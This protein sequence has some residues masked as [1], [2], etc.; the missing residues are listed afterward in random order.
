MNLGFH[1][2][3]SVSA[4]GTGLSVS[5]SSPLWSQASSV[6]SPRRKASG[7][8]PSIVNTSNGQKGGCARLFRYT[9]IGL[10][11]LFGCG[12]L[13]TFLP[14][15]EPERVS[16]SPASL[17]G[18]PI[19][20]SATAQA[21]AL[22]TAPVGSTA[23]VMNIVDGDTIDVLLD[24]GQVTVRY[25]GVDA[26][27]IGQSGYPAAT[28]ANRQLVEGQSVR[29]ERDVSDTDQDGRLLRYVF[30]ADG[31]MVNRVLVAQGW[32]QPLMIAP[33]TQHTADFHDAAVEAWQS[34]Q[35]FW[36]GSSGGDGVMSYAITTVDRATVQPEPRKDA[37]VIES[38]PYL[39]PLT[40]FGRTLDSTW[41]QVRTSTGSGGW[42]ATEQVQTVLPTSAIAVSLDAP[43]PLAVIVP[44]AQ[45]QPTPEPP[46]VP[47]Q[48]AAPIA[49][50]TVAPTAI[51]T[52]IPQ[53]QERAVVVPI[54]GDTG[55][56]QPFTCTGG[57]TTPPD[58]SCSI[59][60][61]VNSDG[62][63]IYHTTDS[64]SYNRTDIKPEEGDR[65]FCTEQE[66]QAAGFRAPR[67]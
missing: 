34:Q 21:D 35:G 36:S 1:R 51:P 12:I 20:S 43:A 62:E 28:E 39:T 53:V 29:L 24:G 41:L 6:R 16:D 58:P 42:I 64:R 14:E 55:D 45:P 7:S 22:P 31:R 57:C 32:A 67:N 9:L 66:A 37:S 4:P 18:T 54:G 3:I 27:E 38:L 59:K 44:T 56:G 17:S 40:V 60:G 15:S 5:S 49:I 26:P 63:R 2:L 52:A 46:P 25:I 13:V 19:T 23:T 65:W 10:G 30:L 8:P 47:D 50:P 33:D 48:A 11:V 61:N